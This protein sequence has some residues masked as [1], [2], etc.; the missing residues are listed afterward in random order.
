[1]SDDEPLDISDD[2][3][4]ELLS[5]LPG[6]AKHYHRYVKRCQ[7]AS[8]EKRKRER[9][10][11]YLATNG[12]GVLPLPE[13]PRPP[14]K[15]RKIQFIDPPAADPPPPP[16]GN[17][18]A[19]KEPLPPSS[20]PQAP[21]VQA[22]PAPKRFKSRPRKLLPPPPPTGKAK[23]ER[24]H[25]NGVQPPPPTT[26]QGQDQGQARDR[27][28]A[29]A[30]VRILP[31]P[32]TPE[33]ARSNE[34]PYANGWERGMRVAN[35]HLSEEP[36]FNCAKEEAI[37]LEKALFV[38]EF[39]MRLDTLRRRSLGERITETQKAEQHATASERADWVEITNR[40]RTHLVADKIRIEMRIKQEE[41]N[42]LRMTDRLERTRRVIAREADDAIAQLAASF[43]HYHPDT[44]PV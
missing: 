37:W 1:M 8:N 3:A 24:R 6:R 11:S 17:P 26:G 32:T 43:E 44:P 5:I 10:A 39:E 14:R 23:T 13:D 19:K 28:T 18:T 42:V 22:A 35:R 21:A 20:A 2:L 29:S 36:R 15:M 12:H 9:L 34:S 4:E 40:E 38:K 25:T 31:T 30:P 7:R 27:L 41:E 16:K 33:L